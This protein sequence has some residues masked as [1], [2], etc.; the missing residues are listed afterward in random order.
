MQKF[1]KK[2]KFKNFKELIYKKKKSPFFKDSIIK[3]INSPSNKS[4]KNIKMLWKKLFY[5]RL[6]V[7]AISSKKIL[8]PRQIEII[9]DISEAR[10]IN[11][12]KKK[13]FFQKELFETEHKLALLINKQDIGVKKKL[14]F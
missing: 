10:I 13:N 3:E 2:C 14:F 11:N 9:H 8:T 5:A 7:R 12:S 6:L 4:K 1:I